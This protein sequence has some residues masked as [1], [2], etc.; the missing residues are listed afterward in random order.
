MFLLVPAYVGCPGSKAVKRSLLLL[1]SEQL[2][3]TSGDAVPGPSGPQPMKRAT[4][5]AQL[6]QTTA[7]GCTPQAKL[8]AYLLQYRPRLT[9]T[10]TV[11]SNTI[12]NNSGLN[13]DPW[14]PGK[15]GR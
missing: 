6:R 15:K 10:L 12:T 2:N 13:P 7:S 9:L 3:A 14:S 8:H 4:T 5:S 1:L 11:I